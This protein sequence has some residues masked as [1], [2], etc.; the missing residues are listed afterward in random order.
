M[1]KLWFFVCELTTKLDVSFWRNYDPCLWLL[2]EEDV[3]FYFGKMSRSIPYR[4]KSKNISSSMITIFSFEPTQV[5]W[6]N[7]FFCFKSYYMI[8]LQCLLHVLIGIS[9]VTILLNMSHCVWYV[10]VV[11]DVGGFSYFG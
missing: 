2:M 9:Q 8:Q 11:E 6:F 4:K 5:R 10:V 1:T 3:Y 7:L